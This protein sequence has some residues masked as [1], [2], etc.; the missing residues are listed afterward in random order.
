MLVQEDGALVTRHC[1]KALDEA[2][3]W[4]SPQL[5]GTLCRRDMPETSKNEI[6]REVRQLF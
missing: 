2:D 4:Q 6:D 5:E 1:N 3:V